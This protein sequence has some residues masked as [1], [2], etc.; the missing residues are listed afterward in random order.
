MLS[1]PCMDSTPQPA[2]H[3]M[4]FSYHHRTKE[5]NVKFMHQ[6]LCNPPKSSLL[7]AICQGFL[8]GVPHL[9]TKAVSKYLPQSLAT[10]KGHMKRPSKGLRSTTPKIPHLATPIVV[11]DVPMPNFHIENEDKDDSHDGSLPNFIDN[12]GNHSVANIFCFG[13]VAE[14]NTRVVNNDCTGKFPF[15]SLNGNIC[16][17]CDVSLQNNHH[18]CKSHPRA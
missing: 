18:P 6:S 1:N 10:S 14:K 7:A 12:I 4:N 3:A 5:I 17:F 16:L 8:R 11:P 9:A 15:M 2:L 13:V